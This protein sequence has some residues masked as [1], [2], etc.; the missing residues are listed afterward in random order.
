M[1][2]LEIDSSISLP[3]GKE[4]YAQCSDF[5]KKIKNEH[6]EFIF[7]GK[8]RVISREE[9]LQFI[10]E[11]SLSHKFS[12]FEMDLAYKHK[13]SR[14]IMDGFL[15]L[16]TFTGT[17]FNSMLKKAAPFL[18]KFNQCARIENKKYPVVFGFTDEIIGKFNQAI[19]SDYYHEG[20]SLFKNK[21]GEKIF[22]EDINLF[23]ISLNLEMGC[24][25]PFDHEGHVRKDP[26]LPII[27]KGKFKNLI[28][29]LRNGFKY[30][31]PSSGNGYRRFD[32]NVS[33]NP[34]PLKFSPGKRNC[35][36]I[37]KDLPE[38]IYIETAF[39]GDWNDLGEYSTPVQNSFL[40][41]NGKV[42]G[43]LPPITVKGSVFD[44]FGEDFIEMA[45]DRI[46]TVTP[47]CSAIFKMNVFKN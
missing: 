26:K 33:L 24:K 14:G 19:M 29:D 35:W 23:D 4:F 37:L 12:Q 41:K 31:A 1:K 5:L 3:S 18:E 16:N 11:A 44:F 36:N 25:N 15:A 13:K 40:L 30:K 38:C 34:N 21:L 20:A 9:N 10:G 32:S 42:E 2:S 47:H 45:S 39:G 27:E 8:I 28:Y 22:H 6:P 17:D 43:R 7:S 46:A